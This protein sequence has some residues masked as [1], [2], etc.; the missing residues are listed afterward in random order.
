MKECWAV[1][2]GFLQY[3][4]LWPESFNTVLT[5]MYTSCKTLSS[6]CKPWL[7]HECWTVV[8]GV[9]DS[10]ISSMLTAVSQRSSHRSGRSSSQWAWHQSFI[11]VMTAPLL[12]WVRT[13]KHQSPGLPSRKMC[14]CVLLTLLDSIFI[15]FSQWRPK[16]ERE[17]EKHRFIVVLCSVWAQ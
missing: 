3:L 13:V 14:V 1:C 2:V 8:R 16:R 7:W 6:P 5:H 10:C 15:H 9:L 4:R 17:R 12:Y 11:S